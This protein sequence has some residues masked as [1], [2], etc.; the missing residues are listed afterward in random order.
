MSK[1]K[2]LTRKEMHKII[3]DLIRA[4]EKASSNF[5]PTSGSSWQ[6][7]RDRNS[8]IASASSNKFLSLSIAK[9]ERFISHPTFWN[10]GFSEG[11]Y[12]SY[13]RQSFDFIDLMHTKTKSARKDFISLV[14]SR[15]TSDA[16]KYY[17]KLQRLILS[18]GKGFWL[19][20]NLVKNP[21]YHNKTLIANKKNASYY[22]KRV[23]TEVNTAVLN[24]CVENCSLSTLR[25]VWQEHID[26]K[27]KLNWQAQWIAKDRLGKTFSQDLSIKDSVKR[28]ISIHK[29]NG[30]LSWQAGNS[31]SLLISNKSSAKT[32]LNILSSYTT[33]KDMS[34]FFEDRWVNKSILDALSF[35]DKDDLVYYLEFGSYC[36]DVFEKRLESKWG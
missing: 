7:D 5:K 36:S 30:Y 1:T 25:S 35:I 15:I 10:N 12:W 32:Y 23:R 20:L 16:K 31:L 26:G 17:P 8:S 4:G 18:K 14:V 13:S 27:R 2:V 24:S 34:S 33:D 6:I 11:S 21:S 22:N 29:E 9:I 28:L 19:K 3:D